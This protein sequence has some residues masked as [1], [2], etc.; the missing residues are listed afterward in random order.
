MDSDITSWLGS[1]VA[2][3]QL[4]APTE[5]QHTNDF[6][7]DCTAVSDDQLP[8]PPST[9]GIDWSRLRGFE[10]PPPAD[11]RTAGDFTSLRMARITGYVGTA[12][13]TK[14]SL[15]I[16]PNSPISVRRQRHLLS[17]T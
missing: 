3:S 8:N 14:R 2:T 7:S 13:L 10:H 15:R 1:T 6:P 5:I 17:I 16:R 9:F 4:D 12:I 11:K